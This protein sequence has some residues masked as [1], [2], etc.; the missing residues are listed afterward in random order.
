MDSKIANILLHPK[1]RLNFYT[2]HQLFEEIQEHE[3]KIKDLGG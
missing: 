1:S 2:T 3:E